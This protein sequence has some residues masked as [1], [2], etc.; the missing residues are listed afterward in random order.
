MPAELVPAAPCGLLARGSAELRT[1]G[2]D[3][4]VREVRWI[5]EA[6]AG[7][8]GAPE[9]FATMVRRRV[10]GEPLAHVLG[11]WQFRHLT[12]TITPQVLIPRPETEGLVDLVLER[13]RQGRVLDL[14][15]GSGC[16]AL[17]LAM[18]GGF[19]QVVAVDRSRAA[20]EVARGNARA[21]GLAVEFIQG[22]FGRTL[23]SSGF[24]VIVSNPPYLTEAEFG[25]LDPSVREHEPRLALA[26]GA[27]GLDATRA[28][29]ADAA[30]LL[31]PGGWV[32]VEL[33]SSR[34]EAS[35]RLAAGAGLGAITVHQDLFAR[36]RF[37]LAQ[38]SEG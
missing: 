16:L 19:K 27:D 13:V 30:R 35:A 5:W 8:P 17:A 12:L 18:E 32:A 15:T 25:D 10:R 3:A 4:A 21:T 20:L 9:R 36:E 26:S 14:G 2:I 24:D 7:T 34:A 38:R 6:V 33:D 31:R 29:L 1:A 23:A 22:D 11:N 28:V 37:L